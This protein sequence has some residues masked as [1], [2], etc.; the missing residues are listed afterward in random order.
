MTNESPGPADEAITTAAELDSA[1]YDILQSAHT[2]G[3]DVEQ[4]WTFRNGDF[5][6]DWEVLIHE[7]AKNQ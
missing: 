1:L 6:P 7:L 4:T 2:N 3:L 5:K